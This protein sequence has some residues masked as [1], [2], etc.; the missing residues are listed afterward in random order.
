MKTHQKSSSLFF[1]NCYKYTTQYINLSIL[2]TYFQQNNIRYIFYS[3]QFIQK[4]YSRYRISVHCCIN[5]YDRKHLL[6][7]AYF[8]IRYIFYAKTFLQILAD[9]LD[10]AFAVQH[11]RILNA[12]DQSQIL[13]HLST[14]DRGTGWPIVE[15]IRKGHKLRNLIQLAALS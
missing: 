13:G 7:T 12:G 14:L 5:A 15:F 2:Y 1:I 9:R 4:K 10:K 11:G 8:I 6:I 3:V